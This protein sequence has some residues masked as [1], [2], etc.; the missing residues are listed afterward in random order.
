[1]KEYEYQKILALTVIIIAIII[2]LIYWSSVLVNENKTETT[3]KTPKLMIR[4]QVAA[5][6]GEVGLQST[7][8]EREAT[9]SAMSKQTASSKK[10]ITPNRDYMAQQLQK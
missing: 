3:T 7:Q 5:A 8:A 4:E 9:L 10:T 1:M 6:L 2:G